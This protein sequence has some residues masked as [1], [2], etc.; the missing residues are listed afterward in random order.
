MREETA[1]GF[2]VLRETSPYAAEIHVMGVL[3]EYH[4][5]GIG[6]RLFDALKAYAVAQ[7]YA[8]LQVKTVQSGHYEEYDRTNAFYRRMGFRELE[9]LPTLWDEWNP[10]Q[11]YVMS[12]GI[13]NMKQL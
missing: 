3:P 9:V 11:V 7:G 5:K 2:A 4:R 10:C 12:I 13:N 8:F 1:V 6:T